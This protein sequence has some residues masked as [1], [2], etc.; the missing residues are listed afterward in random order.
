VSAP[1]SP[2]VSTCHHI[3]CPARLWTA[4][5]A[6]AESRGVS[7]A[8]ALH[9]IMRAELLAHGVTPPAPPPPKRNGPRRRVG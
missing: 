1:E 2:D 4:Y 3:T 6:L 7:V 9:G 8:A 5:A